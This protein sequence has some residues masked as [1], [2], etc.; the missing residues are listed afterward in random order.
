VATALVVSLAGCSGASTGSDHG[1]SSAAL[2]LGLS[3]FAPDQR[4]P[5]PAISG[6]TLTGSTLDL[7]SLSGSVVVLNV[8]A[9][10][11]AECRSES[12]ALAQL[13]SDPRLSKVRFVGL[14]EQD[15]P[16]AARAFATSAGTTYPHLVDRDGSMLA[17][18]PL[19][20]VTAIP[21]TLVIDQDGRVAARVIGAL[22]AAAL[23]K[24]LISLQRDG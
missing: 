22:D 4:V 21:S 10:W 15:Q 14:D 1:S 13:A 2:T 20:P 19:V 18:I 5:F 8:W 3:T 11:C 12:P 6:P 23:R 9:S 17:R 24:E 16:A 7:Q